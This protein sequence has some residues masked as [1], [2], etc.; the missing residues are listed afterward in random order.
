MKNQNSKKFIVE[1][2]H[3]AKQMGSG[4]LDVLATP[5]LVAFMEDTAKDLVKDMLN[6]G[7][8]TVGI[9]IQVKHTKASKLGEAVSC[10]ADMTDNNG[11]IIGFKIRAEDSYGDVIGEADH[12]RAI[13]DADQFMAKLN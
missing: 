8:T 6:P 5:A 1:D 3:S 2:K 10:I 13:V 9:E 7:E 4:D 12:L 11:K